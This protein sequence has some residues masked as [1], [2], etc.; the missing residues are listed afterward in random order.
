MFGSKYGRMVQGTWVHVGT[1]STS[2]LP[3]TFTHRKFT[4]VEPQE[5]NEFAM[6]L[7]SGRVMGFLTQDV[8]DNGLLN[9]EGFKHF[10][11]QKFDNPVKRG[12]Y[13]S[14]R[15]PKMKSLI[16]SEGLGGSVP[17][18][19]VRTTG[20]TAIDGSTTWMKELTCVNGC[21]QEAASG[22]FI[23]GYFH[24]LVDPVADD[25]NT[26]VLWEW[27]GAMSKLA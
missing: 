9:D 20:G 10:I 8:D 19:L 1:M 6:V 5:S 7:G 24:R 22:D 17:G 2:G 11:I 16:E 13:V 25:G 26:R 14:V 27:A 21:L 4:L 18:N 23:V 15:V 3:A 12:A